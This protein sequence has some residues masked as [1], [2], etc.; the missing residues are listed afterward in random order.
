[1]KGMLFWLIVPLGVGSFLTLLSCFYT[2][3][4]GP[5]PLDYMPYGTSER[6]QIGY[7]LPVF[8]SY[9]EY[10][11]GR[12]QLFSDIMFVWPFA[13]MNMAIYAL[14]VSGVTFFGFNCYRVV[15]TSAIQRR[16]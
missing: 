12:V 2:S 13:L 7:P 4:T 16:R 6:I 8:T 9:A 11:Q 10:T 15:K 14:V 1:M 3:Q 5:T